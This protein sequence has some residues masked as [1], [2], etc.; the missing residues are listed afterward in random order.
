M[1]NEL[2]K[3]ETVDGLDPVKAQQVLANAA[4]IENWL[5]KDKFNQMVRVASMLSKSQLVPQTYQNRP[6]D[7]LIAFDMASRIGVNPLMVMQNL[8]VVKGKPSWSGQACMA[9][10]NAS[11]NFTDVKHNYF[12]KEGTDERGCYVSALRAGTLEEIE[13]VKV[14]MAMA[15]AEGWTSNPKWR[16]MPELMLAYRASAFFARVYCPEMLMGCQMTD[17]VEDTHKQQS[18]GSRLTAQLDQMMNGGNEE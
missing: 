2:M 12:G 15:K 7:C 13:G 18:A 6:E 11:G 17:E 14:T 9:L 5:N 1:E 16:N 10:I 8:Y 4:P 3:Q